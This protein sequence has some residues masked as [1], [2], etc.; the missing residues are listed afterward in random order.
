MDINVHLWLTYNPLILKVLFAETK[1]LTI[2]GI[3]TIVR[4]CRS[5]I[6]FFKA[7]NLLHARQ[8]LKSQNI[9]I[10]FLNI[11]LLQEGDLQNLRTNYD[12]K[13]YL[14]VPKASYQITYNRFVPKVFD[15]IINVENDWEANRKYLSDIIEGV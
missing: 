9:S 1:K 14:M 8:I 10:L 2:R 11:E 15:G 3:S 12:G 5:D 6:E 4:D 7:I 13:L